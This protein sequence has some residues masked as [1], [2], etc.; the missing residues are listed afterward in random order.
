VCGGKDRQV[1]MEGGG[2][3]TGSCFGTKGDT[4]AKV[5]GGGILRHRGQGSCQERS[6]RLG[7]KGINCLLKDRHSAGV[8]R[9]R[10]LTGEIE[11]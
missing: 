2:G 1:Y 5:T 8:A 6:R 9:M 3:G 10:G 7:A 4:G 11:V